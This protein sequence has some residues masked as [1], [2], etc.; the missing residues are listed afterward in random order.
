RDRPPVGDD[1]FGRQLRRRA[2]IASVTQAHA[3]QQCLD[4]ASRRRF[5]VRAR[6]VQ[7]LV[8][9]LGLAEHVCQRPDAVQRRFDLRLRPALVQL[10]LDDTQFLAALLLSGTFLLF[11][12]LFRVSGRGARDEIV[13][14]GKLRWE[15]V[16]ADLVPEIGGIQLDITGIVVTAEHRLAED[17]IVVFGTVVLGALE[18][19]T[20]EFGTIERIPV[21]GA[22]V[23]GTVVRGTIVR[24]AEV[25]SWHVSSTGLTLHRTPSSL[26]AS[27]SE[28]VT[29][30]TQTAVST[31]LRA[32]HAADS[33]RW[34]PTRP[35]DRDADHINARENATS[36]P[37][38]PWSPV[39]GEVD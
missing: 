19:G 8:T 2:G 33:T 29:H 21:R 22:V 12:R 1:E 20:V 18:L 25:T 16:L 26:R 35:H 3:R 23:P 14:A 9:V 39:R 5:P 30:R 38:A 32:P 24:D 7:Y 28:A 11:T 31:A 10:R 37:T 13:P 17:G 34:S 15:L 27:T 4:H 6:D 36:A